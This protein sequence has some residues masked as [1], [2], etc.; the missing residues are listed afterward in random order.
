MLPF[1]RSVIQDTCRVTSRSQWVTV[2]L[3]QEAHLTPST[4]G[5]MLTHCHEPCA[6]TETRP[7]PSSRR[8]SAS[9]D[10]MKRA[11]GFEIIV[12]HAHAC[13]ILD[14]RKSHPLSGSQL[15]HLWKE[16]SVIYKVLPS[17]SSFLSFSSLFIFY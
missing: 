13:H 10:G 5:V 16:R 7:L 6:V 9:Y 4:T 1:Y 14:L 3:L 8:G 17:G 11:L 2:I 15:P 12:T